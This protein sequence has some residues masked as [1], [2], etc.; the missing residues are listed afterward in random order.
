MDT[1]DPNEVGQSSEHTEQPNSSLKEYEEPI[2][3]EN[4]DLDHMGLQRITVQRWI[5]TRV[6]DDLCDKHVENDVTYDESN[7][8]E[9]KEAE[10]PV[11]DESDD[12]HERGCDRILSI[13][14]PTSKFFKEFKFGEFGLKEWYMMLPISK[15][16]KNKVV[17]DVINSLDH[18]YD[19]LRTMGEILK[20]DNQIP[21]ALLDPSK[22]KTIQKKR[23]VV[24]P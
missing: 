21:L 23:K 9:V 20:I 17:P 5:V 19:E 22:Q 1:K 16:K 12:N 11:K 24:E 7:L 8:E 14:K 10:E 3:L 4:L 18:K 6:A 13:L 15:R 2:T